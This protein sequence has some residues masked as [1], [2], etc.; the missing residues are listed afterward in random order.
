MENSICFVVVFFESFPKVFSQ[1]SNWP[2]ISDQKGGKNKI[3]WRQTVLLIIFHSLIYTYVL[4]NFIPGFWLLFRNFNPWTEVHCWSFS[5]LDWEILLDCHGCN[6]FGKKIMVEGL[7]AIISALYFQ[8]ELMIP[9]YEKYQESKTIT[10]IKTTNYPVWNINFPGVT[11]C[12]NNKVSK[13]RSC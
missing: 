12:S 1:K 6:G 3:S 4:S 8:Y 9:I 13:S 2:N 11:I 5:A 10:S 7:I